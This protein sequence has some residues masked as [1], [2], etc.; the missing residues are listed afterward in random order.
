MGPLALAVA[1]V[2]GGCNPGQLPGVGHWRCSDPFNPDGDS[3]DVKADGTITITTANGQS[4]SGTWTSNGTTYTL[5]GLGPGGTED[6]TLANDKFTS[7]QTGQVC[8]RA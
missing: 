3:V 8:T 6:W 1:L 2:I 4:V 7:N 5:H